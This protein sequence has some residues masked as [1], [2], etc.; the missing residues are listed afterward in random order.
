MNNSPWVGG[1]A[2][3]EGVM[4]RYRNR[5]AIACRRSD[6][7]IG[8]HREVITPLSERFPP[9]GWP[10]VRGAVAFFEALIIGVRALNISAAEALGEED[11]ELTGW[12]S[13]IMV[14]FGL[15]LGIVL[16]FILPTFLVR[17][18]P[19]WQPVILNLIE[20]LIRLL[21]F[22]GYIALITRWGDIQ[23]FF[24]YH[25]A[26]HK[27]IFGYESGETQ[28]LN[29]ISGFSARHP[30]CGTSFILTVMVVSILLFSL[31]GWPALWQ[32]ILLRVFLLPLV[33][34]LSYEIIRLS[35][36]SNSP[37]VCWLTAPGLW[38]QNLTTR[39]PDCDQ[40]EVALCALKA[41]INPSEQEQ[42]DLNGED[43]AEVSADAR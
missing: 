24:Q 5:M 30:R 31:F 28:D 6:N 43:K 8:I 19:S 29:R 14:V 18:L 32:R 26:E 15:G 41:V 12:H 11:E 10:V 13:F 25:G 2:V 36:R 7:T 4:M 27:V 22:I 16:F 17:F 35:A 33:A 38:L 21:I 39:E 34:G 40:L 20:G 9:L 37:I 1:Q 42:A 23:R 3:L